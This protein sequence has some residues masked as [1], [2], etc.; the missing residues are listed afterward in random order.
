MIL[1]YQSSGQA[2]TNWEANGVALYK[3]IASHFLRMKKTGGKNDMFLEGEQLIPY[4]LCRLEP[5]LTRAGVGQLSPGPA[6]R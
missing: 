1:I 2:N 3:I 4:C 6:G 5:S